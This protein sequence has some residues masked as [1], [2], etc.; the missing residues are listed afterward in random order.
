MA[1]LPPGW[2]QID[3]TSVDSFQGNGVSKQLGAELRRQ[4]TGETSLMEM[5]ELEDEAEA[6]R[7]GEEVEEDDPNLEPKDGEDA[8][9]PFGA[10]SSTLDLL[11]EQ[12]TQIM[13]KVEPESEPQVPV[14]ER[15]WFVLFM[16]LVVVVN[17]V[18][19]GLEVDLAA[20]IP[21]VFIAA[22]NAFLILYMGE[23]GLRF[24]TYRFGIFQDPL[25]VLDLILVL[26]VFVEEFAFTGNLARSLPAFRLLRLLRLARAARYMTA[27]PQLL[28]FI[29]N[30]TRTMKTLGWVCLILCVF[31]FSTAA[32]SHYVI[33]ESA[34]WNDTFDPWQE[35]EAF[36]AFDNRQYFGSVTRSFLTLMQVIT[37]SQWANHVARPVVFRYPAIAGFLGF[38]LLITTF[39]L[40]SSVVANIVQDALETSR[41][42]ET[43]SRE[44]EREN[45]QQMG[46]K[47][48][49]LL[50]LMDEDGDG[51]MAQH[52]VEVALKNEE[53]R[54]TL[55]DL[56]VPVLDAESLMRLFDKD[57]KGF[58]TFDFLV[59]GL[60]SMLDDIDDKDWTFLAIWSEGLHLRAD[61]VERRCELLFQGVLRLHGLLEYCLTSLY[62]FLDSLEATT[63]H[64]RALRYVR[65]APPP[66][67]ASIYEVLNIKVADEAP[68]DEAEA[69]IGFARRYMG[70][71]DRLAPLS[72]PPPL[73]P[74]P[75]VRKTLTNRKAVLPPAPCKPAVYRARHLREQVATDA[76]N[77][78]YDVNAIGAE[79]AVF[80]KLKQELTVDPELLE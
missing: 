74:F 48:R 38:F 24:V 17:A 60:V 26:L 2:V 56:E 13:A 4:G 28:A 71:S 34:V 33:G 64:Y 31:V 32:C 10:S 7:E 73:V 55:L 75:D 68:M 41:I 29:S 39:G 51:Q 8:R 6:D 50:R 3:P 5:F 18:C 46:L 49:T 54:Q 80:A 11:Q 19:I 37:N 66:I 30:A 72:E 42:L 69:F 65:S 53:F 47:A 23:L 61:I 67:A 27:S 77:A 1:T 14:V 45:R 57:G 40:L 35:Y 21:I 63:R 36:E 79:S 76:H 59:K 44:V 43:S 78:R 20:T 52:E 58:I 9:R 70:P 62:Q 15:A 12:A 22:N 16:G 25:T